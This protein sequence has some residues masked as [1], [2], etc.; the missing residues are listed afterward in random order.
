VCDPG[1]MD[2]SNLLDA[3]SVAILRP[4]FIGPEEASVLFARIETDTAWESSEIRMFGRWV[5]EPR[6]VAWQGEPGMLYRY[7][8]VTRTPSPFGPAVLE[9]RERLY[10]EIGHRFN[11]V[12]LNFYR[13]GRDS[14]G[15]HRDNEPELGPEPW[16]ASISLGAPRRFL[17]RSRADRGVKREVLLE[18]GGLLL[19]GGKTQELWDHAIPKSL[20]VKAPRINL[21]FRMI[22]ARK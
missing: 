10:R 3:P 20:K 14:M 7:S 11:S 6:R 4:G 12:L 18:S 22:Q 13:D 5:P 9:L 21:T 2:E 1:G 19:M 15:W 8:G 16:I 17:F